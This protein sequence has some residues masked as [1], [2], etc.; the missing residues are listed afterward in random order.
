M[1]HLIALAVCI[2]AAV[3]E[4]LCAGL[5]PMEQLKATR[6]PRWSPPAWL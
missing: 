6:Q 4:G 2:A 1:N 5:K 3:A